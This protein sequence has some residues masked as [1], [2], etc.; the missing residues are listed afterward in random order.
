MNKLYIFYSLLIIGLFCGS[1]VDA[2]R[3]F[4][5]P[6][7][8]DPTMPTDIQ[9]IIMGDTSETGER[10]DMNTIYT[11]QNGAVYVVSDQ[12]ANQGWPLQIQAADLDNI[13]TK[14]V[15]SRIPNASGD[16]PNMLRAFGDLTLLN[17]WVIAGERGP[18]EQMDWGKNRIMG[19]SLTV[20]ID[21][22]IFEK[23][24][25]GFVQ[26]RGERA[27]VYI[28][29]S[30][31]RN[32]ANR[33]IL[34]GNG[35]VVDARTT[36]IDTL[37]V[38]NCVMH[39]IVDRIFR[40]QGGA[41]PHN[42]IEFD[43]NTIFNHGGRHGTFQFGKVLSAKITNN[44]MENPNMSGTSPQYTD[45]QTQPDNEAHHV[46]TVDTLFDATNFT[47]ANNNIYYTQDVLDFNLGNRI[48]TC[49]KI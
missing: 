6:P 40:S 28:T 20:V 16:W 19:D 35:R 2:Q 41:E 34:E 9:P 17:L 33:F 4:E 45:E 37:V 47:F 3:I 8:D 48:I 27:K 36:A 42:Y 7:S 21:N 38:R 32:A 31:F 1:S 49:V 22:C 25:G 11:L 14:P 15:I 18:G 13:A 46:F 39:N 43:Q 12:I 26:L 24:R 5:I 30:V 10:T 44:V 23:D 29:N